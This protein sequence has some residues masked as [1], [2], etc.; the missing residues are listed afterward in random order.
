MARSRAFDLGPRLVHGVLRGGELRLTGLEER[1]DVSLFAQPFDQLALG[2]GERGVGCGHG[3]DGALED[4]LRLADAAARLGGGGPRRRVGGG[5]PLLSGSRGG[6]VPLGPGQR[7]LGGGDLRG[8]SGLGKRVHLLAADRARLA[9]LERAA[10]LVRHLGMLRIHDGS[11]RGFDDRERDREGFIRA[12][13]RCGR[14]SGGRLPLLREGPHRRDLR[15]SARHLVA[16]GPHVFDLAFVRLHQMFER[17]ESFAVAVTRGDVGQLVLPLPADL[18]RLLAGGPRVRD[19]RSRIPRR[20]DRGPHVGGGG[21]SRDDLLQ[22]LDPSGRCLGVARGRVPLLLEPFDLRSGGVQC[23]QP[24]LRRPSGRTRLVQPGSRVGHA[25]AFLL[26]R[27]QLHLHALQTGFRHTQRVVQPFEP[28]DALQD[29]VALGGRG[30][31]EL[32]EAVL[33]QEHRA[34]E[35]LEIHPQQLFDARVHVAL[36]RHRLH[37]VGVRLVG[38]EQLEL[39]SRRPLAAERPDRA[40]HL[41]VHLEP[42]LHVRLVGQLMDQRLGRALHLR[43]LPVQRERDRVQDRGLPRADRADDPDQTPVAPIERGAAAVGAEAFH[44]QL[45]RSHRPPRER[46]G[47]ARAGPRARPLRARAGRTRRRAPPTS[48]GPSPAGRV[49][50]RRAAAP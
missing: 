10:E 5:A 17:T 29:R 21:Q 12:R 49:G 16:R 27:G 43:R 30:L 25:L 11:A 37:D 18:L 31:Q 2:G 46:R 8:G 32:R 3:R 7:L 6:L 41:A 36:E 35:R 20:G 1:T 28:E 13:E 50:R 23:R 38:G 26:E 9:G 45:K 19:S 33:R 34:A 47:R 22:R 48:D 44:G 14:R 39:M 24:S 4:G 40:P 42:Q 15:L